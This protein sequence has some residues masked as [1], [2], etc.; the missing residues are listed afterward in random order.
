MCYWVWSVRDTGDNSLRV[1]HDNHAKG[2]LSPSLSAQYLY[3]FVISVVAL[4]QN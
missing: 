3:D 1:K 4:T 2:H